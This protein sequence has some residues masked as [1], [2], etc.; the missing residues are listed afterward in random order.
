MD[1]SELWN[2]NSQA[3]HSQAKTPPQGSNDLI[4]E[5]YPFRMKWWM[6]MKC[7][8]TIHKPN[9]SKKKLPTTLTFKNDDSKFGKYLVQFHTN[10]TQSED[11]QMH[12]TRI[13]TLVVPTWEL[14]QK[15]KIWWHNIPPPIG[16]R[17]IWLTNTML[18]RQV[19]GTKSW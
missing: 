12:I 17:N 9:T 11:E 16:Y 10:K 14:Q 1:A 7:E 3:Q 13:S 6:L 2:H 18:N 19:F 15:L 8:I 4:T 5:D